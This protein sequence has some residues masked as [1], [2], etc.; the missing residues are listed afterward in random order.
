MIQ[1]ARKSRKSKQAKLDEDGE[2]YTFLGRAGPCPGLGRLPGRRPRVPARPR[3][4]PRPAPRPA[5]SGACPA[6]RPA[7]AGSQTGD[8][9]SLPGLPPGLG[10][11]P[12]R[13]AWDLTAHRG[14]R[15][16]VLPLPPLHVSLLHCYS[17]PKLKLLHLPFR[18]NH[19]KLLPLHKLVRESPDLSPYPHS[20]SVC[21]PIWE[22][23][24]S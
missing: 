3:A 19:N 1:S 11:F 10:R 7:S 21:V 8:L 24:S 16:R 15:P 14:F 18:F 4:R 23:S 6:S 20:F 13:R 22:G 2:K 5:P 12:G 17:P 9:G